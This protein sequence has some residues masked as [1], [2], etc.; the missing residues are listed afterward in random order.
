[1]SVWLTPKRSERVALVK[2][3]YEDTCRAIDTVA[4]HPDALGQFR[5]LS[6]EMRAAVLEKA[7]SLWNATERTV[8]DRLRA[9]DDDC[10]YAAL[11]TPELV[12]AE[13]RA[14]YRRLFFMPLNDTLPLRFEAE[15]PEH[16]RVVLLCAIATPRALRGAVDL[17]DAHTVELL[18]KRRT[19]AVT[20]AFLSAANVPIVPSDGG[21][22]S[23]LDV[24]FERDD[25]KQRQM[26]DEMPTADAT[27]FLTSLCRPG[28]NGVFTALRSALT[29]TATAHTARVL[30]ALRTLPR[31][32]NDAEMVACVRR[33]ALPDTAYDSFEAFVVK[34]DNELVSKR[35]R[36]VFGTLSRTTRRAFLRLAE[37]TYAFTGH[38]CS[39]LRTYEEDASDSEADETIVSEADPD[40]LP[41]SFKRA[42]AK[43]LELRSELRY[44]KRAR[45]ELEAQIQEVKDDADNA[46]E[47]VEKARADADAA[48]AE[49]AEAQEKVDAAMEE[50]KVACA[51]AETARKEAEEAEEE[52]ERLRTELAT[53]RDERDR[54]LAD[55]EDAEAAASADDDDEVT[56]AG[57][58]AV[59][60]DD[61]EDE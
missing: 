46:E 31:N 52:A 53:V 25:A 20:Q 3:G 23:S 17:V 41:G 8:L 51:E 38:A 33:Y 56:D 27:A 49:A 47:E 14:A 42:R 40:D 44:Q 48:E 32:P 21:H 26:F 50:A 30:W 60:G 61:D 39:W 5:S 22:G 18:W 7:A 12:P 4:T 6:F 16:V 13:Y 11:G 1:M 37:S 28:L 58:G 19:V 35:C 29:M 24:A 57:A 54:A 55:L 45:A 43:Q 10:V 15:F 2:V 36:E 34:R 9:I 59:A